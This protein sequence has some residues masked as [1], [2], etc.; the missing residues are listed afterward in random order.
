MKEAEHQ[1]RPRESYRQRFTFT[2]KAETFHC[3]L[4]LKKDMSQWHAD[5]AENWTEKA[6]IYFKRLRAEI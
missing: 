2:I 3:I 6:D 1:L 4:L 5:K